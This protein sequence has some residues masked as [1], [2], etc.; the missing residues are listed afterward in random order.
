MH[1]NVYCENIL[2]LMWKKSNVYVYPL[3][4]SKIKYIVILIARVIY[5]Y[6]FCKL[7]FVCYFWFKYYE[8]CLNNLTAFKI[9]KHTIYLIF[10]LCTLFPRLR[11][12]NGNVFVSNKKIQSLNKYSYLFKWQSTSLKNKNPKINNYI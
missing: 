7:S 9:L 1:L 12:P 3:F 11:H 2:F 4:S 8:F 10:I 5:L 6:G